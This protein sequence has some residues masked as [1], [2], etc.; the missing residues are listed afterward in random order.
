MRLS[1]VT[2]ERLGVALLLGA[3][4]FVH[5]RRLDRPFEHGF[6]GYQ[7]AFFALAAAGYE[8]HGLASSA[9][10]PAL[11]LDGPC[12]GGLDDLAPLA[13]SGSDASARV[14]YRNHPPSA[15]LLAWSSIRAL[16]PPGWAESSSVPGPPASPGTI[17]CLERIPFLA[18]HLAGLL[19]F[20]WAMRVAAG[21]GFALTALALYATAPVALYY[22]SFANLET[23]SLPGLFLALGF[24]ARWLRTRAKR[25]LAAAGAGLAIASAFTWAPL[26]F[27]PWLALHAAARL[28]LRAGARSGLSLALAAAI[29]LAAHAVL[30]RWIAAPPQDFLARARHLLAPLV[31]GELA[32]G[33]WAALQA[34]HAFAALGPALALAAILGLAIGARRAWIA[35]RE[36]ASIGGDPAR[37]SDPRTA[38]VEITALLCAGALLFHLAFYRHTGE[39][40][41]NFALYLAPAAA[42]AAALVFDALAP[43]LWA[44]RGGLAPLV[45]AVSLVALPGLA[46]ADAFARAQARPEWPSPKELAREVEGLVPQGSVCL[47]PAELGFDLQ[48]ACYAGR[49]LVV[50][51]QPQDFDALAARFAAWSARPRCLL[52][53]IDAEDRAS[54]SDWLEYARGHGTLSKRSG[55]WSLWS[56]R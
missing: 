35:R 47:A 43:R 40:Q 38:P 55:R 13:S 12:W 50:L 31:D 30:S 22:G 23:P 17:E 28:G 16:A 44:L 45:V 14:V 27:V 49:N 46:F 21:R 11:E 32:I 10:Y 56:L 5:A 39:D 19:A 15:M 1:S 6:G 34:E 37:A 2:L 18:L 51:D 29:P 53:S 33:R 36:R 52:L 4:L 9:G 26:A 54:P 7:G 25:D 3:V 24:H 41:P 42:A 48:T 20:W 8:R